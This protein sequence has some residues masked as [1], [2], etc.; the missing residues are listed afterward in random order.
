MSAGRILVLEDEWLIAD[1]LVDVLIS[2][3]YEVVGP[4]S[5][6]VE[7]LSLIKQAGIDAA[8]LDVSL[9]GERSFPVAA[10]LRRIAIPFAFMTGYLETDLP[11]EFH[12]EPVLTKPTR[13]AALV[14]CLSSMLSVRSE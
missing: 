7:A 9:R 14:S 5:C 11:V 6:V 13:P 12:S 8:I 4:A 3:G 2:E 10:E 1:Y